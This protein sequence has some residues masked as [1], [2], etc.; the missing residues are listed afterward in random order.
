[1]KK[2]FHENETGNARLGPGITINS[3]TT[4]IK[5]MK[6]PSNSPKNI[7]DPEISSPS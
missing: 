4:W 5:Q 6:Y 3:N 1:M 2:S 7:P